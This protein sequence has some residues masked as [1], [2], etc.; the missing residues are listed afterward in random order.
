VSPAWGGRSLSARLVLL[1]VSTC[2]NKHEYKVI[3]NCALALMTLLFLGHHWEYGFE[4]A[5]PADRFG[6]PTAL[7][8]FDMANHMS[9]SLKYP[10]LFLLS[11]SFTDHYYSQGA[12][13]PPLNNLLNSSKYTLPCPFGPSECWCGTT[14]KRPVH[15]VPCKMGRM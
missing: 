2:P 14:A 15:A 7:I 6:F 10:S 5:C 3:Y 8:M 13:P 9:I 1:I 12:L 11:H 4:K